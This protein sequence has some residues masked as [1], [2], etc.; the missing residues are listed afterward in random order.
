MG[1]HGP[2]QTGKRKAHLSD[3][4]KHENYE[5]ESER[6]TDRDREREEGKQREGRKEA[7]KNM[8]NIDLKV[9]IL[10]ED[11]NNIIFFP[12]KKPQICGFFYSLTSN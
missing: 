7:V 8:L 4:W 5:R 3:A 9:P 6:Q 11:S 2:P 12:I 1:G 10:I